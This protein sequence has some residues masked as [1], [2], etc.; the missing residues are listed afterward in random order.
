MRAAARSSSDADG[1]GEMPSARLRTLKMLAPYLAEFP[2]RV[3][4][5]LA[6]L[7]GAKLAGVALPLVLGHLVDGLDRTQALLA[8]PL[9]WLLAYGGLRFF[10]VLAGELRDIAFGRV[11][12]RAMRRAGLRVFE[13]LQALDLEFHLGRRTGALARD[14][15]RGVEGIRFLLRFSLFNIAPT[16][17]ELVLVTV[18][19]WGKFDWRYAAIA[20][21][22]VAVYVVFS[23]RVTEWR[24]Q[25]VKQQNQ[26]DSSAGARALDALLNYET[27]KYFGNERFEAQ[28]YDSSLAAWERA[29]AKNRA[30]LSLLNV[31]QA[32]IVAGA[33][34]LMMVL[35]AAQVRAGSMRIGAF[36]AI[37]AY[38]VQLFVPL[39]F[40]G[41]VY[42]ELR[43]AM[44][45]L[46]R[47]FGLLGAA[48]RVVDAPAA[49]EL[50]TARAGVR[51]EQIRFGYQPARQI[52]RGVNFEI[53]PG[54]K[55]AV[56]GASGAGKSTIARLLFRFYDADAGDVRVGG[57]DVREWT[58]ASLRAHIGVVPQDTVLFN[59]SIGYNIAYGRP[60]ASRAEIERAAAM[61]HLDTFIASL[62]Q[63]YD[64]PVGERGLKLSGGEK[65]RIAIARAMLK[66]PPI[67]ILDEATSSLDSHAE[68]AIL[69]ALRE[70]GARR[71]V[72]AVAHRLSTITDADEI[73]VLENGRIVERGTHAELLARG[74]AYARSWRLQQQRGGVAGAPSLIAAG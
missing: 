62:P 14:I 53:P 8:L 35:A 33:I 34:T 68:A 12:D 71:T 40:L 45:D 4:L 20:F 7:V 46:Q 48:P 60:Q 74:G 3:A 37:N 44:I 31:G 16:L 36:V 66:D 58:Q 61:A 19:L 23:V 56:V 50:R 11:T 54:H 18:I 27:V 51:F 43:R 28:R 72:L 47:M 59:D 30:S 65:Q 39:N 41:F 10:N 55:L 13:H 17:F 32:V 70:A 26:L 69:E 38:M 5:S 64:T 29:S 21:V 1:T 63:G 57:R 24:T 22:S 25:Y 42:R 52:L 6:F 49:R 67:L 73:V 15:E 9:G 2:G